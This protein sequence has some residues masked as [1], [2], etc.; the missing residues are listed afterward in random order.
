M[1]KITK[2]LIIITVILGLCIYVVI[3]ASY[4]APKR[5]QI[6]E[7]EL[8]SADIPEQLNDMSILYFSDLEYGTYMDE[9]RL[10]KLVDKINSLSPDIIIF[11]GDVYD[12]A[13]SAS[14]ESNTILTNAFKAMKAAYGK[15]AVYGDS[16]DR[17]DEMVTTVNTIYGSSDFEVLNNKAVSLHKQGSGSITLVGIDNIVN[18]KPDVDTVYSTVSRD[19]YVLTV[20]HTPD[21]ALAVPTDITNYFLAGHSHGGQVYY[22]FG[23]L[24]QPEGAKEYLRGTH[25]I[26]GKFT[27]DITN[28]VG[29]TIK[30]VRFLCDAEV[31][32]YKLKHVDE[33]TKTTS[34]A[35]TETTAEPASETTDTPSAA[36]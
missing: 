12:T 32:L 20:C 31:V 18:G 5:Y 1:N 23:A 25:T 22:F 28:G 14:D 27:L 17:S 36:Q 34:A 35:K 13:A 24:Y 26:S 9:E 33:E 8:S 29:T 19:S 2:I 4:A 11:G 16:D 30:D 21:T 10:N 15:Y 7:E 6:R 3:D